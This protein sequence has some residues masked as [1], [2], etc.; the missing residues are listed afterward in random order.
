[1][2]VNVHDRVDK[3]VLFINM[4]LR[5]VIKANLLARNNIELELIPIEA[6]EG[7][8]AAVQN[9]YQRGG[10]GKARWPLFLSL[11]KPGR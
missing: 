3:A 9:S 2:S 1:M 4:Q 7:R 11:P 6:T 8:L 5:L 10:L